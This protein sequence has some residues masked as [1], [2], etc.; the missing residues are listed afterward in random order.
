[1]R[2]VIPDPQAKWSSAI[3]TERNCAIEAALNQIPLL[4]ANAGI[5]IVKRRGLLTYWRT[6]RARIAKLYVEKERVAE[7]MS[8]HR[9]LSVV[10]QLYV[11]MAFLVWALVPMMGDWFAATGSVILRPDLL[12]EGLASGRRR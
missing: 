12:R 5:Q 4:P 11:A 8:Q 7:A 2:R 9:V 3:V 6:V 10:F 1:M